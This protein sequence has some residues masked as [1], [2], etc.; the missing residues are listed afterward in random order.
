MADLTC[1][2]FSPSRGQTGVVR[3]RTPFMIHTVG[4]NN[5][6]WPTAPME[7]LS[8]WKYLDLQGYLP[9]AGRDQPFPWKVQDMD[10]SV[11]LGCHSRSSTWKNWTATCERMK[12]EHSPTSHTKINMEWI[13]DLNVRPDT[14]KLLLEE[15][16][17]RTLFDINHSSIFFGFTS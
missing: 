1:S 9:G 2:V 16:I 8:G 12:L 14:I 7:L 10:N 4:I 11:L 15:N 5:L 17:G 3:P 13:D 6:V